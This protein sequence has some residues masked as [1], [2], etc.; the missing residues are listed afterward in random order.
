MKLGMG[1]EYGLQDRKSDDSRSRSSAR[2][3]LQLGKAEEQ[4]NSG[5]ST[6]AVRSPPTGARD[7]PWPALGAAN[8]AQVPRYLRVYR[9]IAARVLRARAV[10]RSVLVANPILACA[11]QLLGQ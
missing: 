8:D 5:T 2:A 11:S 3:Q 4:K 9:E 6:P 10:R 7:E 1:M